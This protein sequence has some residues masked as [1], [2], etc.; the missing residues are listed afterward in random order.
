MKSKRQL[1]ERIGKKTNSSLVSTL[2]LAKKQAAWS[3]IAHKLSGPT[4]KHASVNLDAIDEIT[5]EG[6]TV[7][8]LGKVLGTGNVSK[9]VRVCALHFSSSARTKLKD[10]KA[11]IV[12]IA[13][14]IKKNPKANGIRVLT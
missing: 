7:V 10:V 12:S 13:D 3:D 2:V 14:E 11:E 9:K 1:R 8:V 4:R 6:D 5:K